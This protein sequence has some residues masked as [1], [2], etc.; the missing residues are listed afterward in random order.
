MKT[1]MALLMACAMWAGAQTQAQFAQSMDSSAQVIAKFAK[2]PAAYSTLPFFV[3]NGELSEK[4]ID[5]VISDYA[6][7]N[8]Q[9]FFIH[10]RPGLITPYLSERWFHLIRYTVDQARKRGMVVWLYDE[11]SYPSGFAGG[12]VPAELP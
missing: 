12:P 6:S 2:P 1:A 10:P 9:G 7:Q 5:R 8:V 4:E 3:W 11:N